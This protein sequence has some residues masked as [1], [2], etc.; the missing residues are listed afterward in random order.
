MIERAER[1]ISLKNIAR[2]AKTFDVKIKDLFVH[3]K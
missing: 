1:N 2:I 3:K